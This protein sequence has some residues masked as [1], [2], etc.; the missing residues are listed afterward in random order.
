MNITIINGSPNGSE[1]YTYAQAMKIRG[2]CMHAKVKT[3]HIN[4]VIDELEK[5]RLCISSIKSKLETCD[6][7]VWATP[8]YIMLVPYQ[9]KLFIEFLFNNGASAFLKNKKYAVVLSSAFLY[10]ST[11]QDYL[12]AVSRDLGLNHLGSIST[13]KIRDSWSKRSDLNK[14]YR[15]I[16]DKYAGTYRFSYEPYYKTHVKKKA[17][18]LPLHVYSPVNVDKKIAVV[19]DKEY[20]SC[21]NLG[22]MLSFI[23]DTLNIK[24]N[25]Y[26]IS[27]C[28]IHGG[29]CGRVYCGY[30]NICIKK[31]G[32]AD[33]ISQL[34]L[35]DVIIF[36]GKITDRFLSSKWKLFF[37]R[38]FFNTHI[39]LFRDKEMAFL[40]DGDLQANSH[41]ETILKAY[42]QWQ[43]AAMRAI[44][45]TA[46][47]DDEYDV[48]DKLYELFLDIQVSDNTKENLYINYNFLGI[49][50]AK[51][52]RDAI[53]GPFR[54]GILADHRYW[55]K[56]KFYDYPNT[57]ISYFAVHLLMGPLCR[58]EWYRRKCFK[59]AET[60]KNMFLLTCFS[61]I[62]LVFS[63]GT[64][65]WLIL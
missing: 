40:V 36:S 13:S 51:V 23:K 52:L 35:N 65:I 21:T 60:M 63:I 31:D 7:V 62:S 8:V 56:N 28:E 27:E 16:Q 19:V 55:K 48:Y 4:E 47:G 49:G 15:Y 45:S 5:G 18:P 12:E 6:I 57:R 9:L 11:A 25:L 50:G 46:Y 14:F 37:D 20:D 17:L 41:L 34:Q 33:F 54:L 32:F 61:Y 59:N 39:P 22:R 10:D 29:C 30:D 38:S 58:F 26:N 42:T 3:I 64:L 43:M 44:V 1:S 2:V 24:F 53:W